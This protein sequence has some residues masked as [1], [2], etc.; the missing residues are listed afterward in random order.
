[1]D[2]LEFMGRLGV[3][4]TEKHHGDRPIAGT[5]T[6]EITM[7]FVRMAFREY[8]AIHNAWQNP[9]DRIKAPKSKKGIG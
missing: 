5:R 2:I 4:K 6:Y 9:F 1:M 8:W 7:R 3:K